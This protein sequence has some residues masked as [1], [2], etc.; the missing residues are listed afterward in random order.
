ML[1]EQVTPWGSGDGAARGGAEV[2]GGGGVSSEDRGSE[3]EDHREDSQSR[4][5]G[6]RGVS[7]AYFLLM[8]LIDL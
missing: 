7:L 2:G 1:S 6:L 4:Q 8:F 3:I 5:S